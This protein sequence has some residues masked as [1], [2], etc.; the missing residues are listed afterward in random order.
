MH[1]APPRDPPIRSLFFVPM[2]VKVNVRNRR[3]ETPLLLAVR[4]DAGDA[5]AALLS[6]G[7]RLDDPDIDGENTLVWYSIG[8]CRIRYCSL[9]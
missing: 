8:E 6:F 2:S 7:A 5:V 3:R 1:A 9:V 4:A